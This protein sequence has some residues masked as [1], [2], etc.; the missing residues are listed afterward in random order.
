MPFYDYIYGTIDKSTDT[1]HSKSLSQ[2]EESPEVVHLT[3]LTTPESMYHM[4][5]G[6]ASLASKPQ[7]SSEW[8]LWILWP[9]TAWSML[10]TRIYGETF[11][12]E[13]NVCKSLVVQ[14][15]AIP[16]YTHH[17]SILLML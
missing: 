8:Y 2:K 4:R 9:V 3:H 5:L 6:F 13:R 14:T 12:I 15:W 16:K 7:T 11:V 17:V 1:L 10:I